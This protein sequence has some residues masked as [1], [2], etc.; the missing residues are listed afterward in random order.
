MNGA[1]SN[2]SHSLEII[3]TG[4][5][6]FYLGQVLE[7]ENRLAEALTA[8][9]Q[10]LKISPDSAELRNHINEILKKQTSAP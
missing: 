2:F 1:I 5:A 6:Y 9:Q 7:R 3:P 8:Y 4:T 10:A